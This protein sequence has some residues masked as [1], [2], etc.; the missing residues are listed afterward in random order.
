MAVERPSAQASVLSPKI[1]LIP[2]DPESMEHVERLYN[3]RVACEWNSNL[4][5]TWR[6]KQREG[7]KT[8]HVSCPL[9]AYC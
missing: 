8:I 7:K 6:A 4:V 9:V 5:E 1:E 3:Q 2:W